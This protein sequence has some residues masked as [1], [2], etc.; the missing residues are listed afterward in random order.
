MKRCESE[1]AGAVN[2]ASRY[3]ISS[4]NMFSLADCQA[5][6]SKR[7]LSRCVPRVVSESIRSSRPWRRP[8]C[9]SLLPP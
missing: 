7:T 6:M 5:M 9:V 3:A 8:T 2:A 1:M 4:F